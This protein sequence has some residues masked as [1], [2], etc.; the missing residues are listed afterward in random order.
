MTIS[1]Y[2]R[3]SW[4]GSFL[5]L[6]IVVLSQ[7][8]CWRPYNTPVFADIAPNET[9]YVIP[10]NGDTTDQA[11]F[12]SVDFLE[13]HKVG[14]KRIQV[15]R[16]WINDGYIPSDGHYQDSVRV[17]KVDRTPV[18][19]SF[20]QADQTLDSNGHMKR[21]DDAIWIESRDSIGFSMGFSVTL[22]IEENDTSTYLYRYPGV[23][24]A[25]EAKSEV[26]ARLQQNAAAFAAR[27]ILDDLR[28]QKN[29]MMTAISKD[30]VPF[31][32]ARGITVTTIGQF[33]GMVYDDKDIQNAINRTFVAEQE[34]V[35][36]GAL[37]T[38]QRDINAKSDQSAHQD[39]R[40]AITRATGEAQAI[41]LVADASREAASNP[42][43]I[44]LRQLEI[45]AQRIA[46]WNGVVPD[47]LIEGGGSSS[48]YNLFIQPKT[49]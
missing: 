27:Y 33:G 5:L 14:A 9:A 13:Q 21:S 36:A 22:R 6:L 40:N 2:L 46:K 43:F 18:T 34:K 30:L 16:V 31:F 8:G 26:K 10:L 7:T 15:P 12:N 19:I 48:P 35:V 44:Q 17:V 49:H 11:K 45:E 24:L 37:L 23:S 20:E 47:T 28:S 3:S 25:D 4:L 29:E 42:V 41:K 38:A 32:A 1:R 39:Q